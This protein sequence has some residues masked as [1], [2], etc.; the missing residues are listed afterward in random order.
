[1]TKKPK[2]LTKELAEEI[3]IKFVQGIDTGTNERKYYTLDALAI[4]LCHINQIKL[5]G[6]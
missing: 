1:M 4:A 3:R 5:E 6:L 2:T